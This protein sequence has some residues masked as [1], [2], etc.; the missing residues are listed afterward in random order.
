VAPSATWAVTITSA[1][2]PSTTPV[3]RRSL[4]PYSEH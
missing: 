2:P 3:R 4:I 1:P